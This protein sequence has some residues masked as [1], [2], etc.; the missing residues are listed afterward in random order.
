MPAFLEPD[1]KFAVVLDIDKAKPKETRPTF[2]VKSLSMREQKRL[3]DDMDTALDCETTQQICDA[4]CELVKRYV[5]GWE[6]MGQYKFGESD[7]QD[8]LSI[9]EARELLRKVLSNSYVQHEEKKS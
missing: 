5:V 4:T 2:F 3:S 6:S 9:Q 8:F 1:Q 7:L